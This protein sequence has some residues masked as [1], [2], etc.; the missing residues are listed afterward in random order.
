M[1]LIREW[2]AVALQADVSIVRDVV[3]LRFRA[4]MFTVTRNAVH[5]HLRGGKRQ[6]IGSDDSHVRD[7][8]EQVAVPDEQEEWENEYQKRLFAWACDEVR[9]EF[10]EHTWQAFWQTA[11]N[12]HGSSV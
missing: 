7:R 1:S 5:K 12:D 10:K 11:V 9:S 4:R 6:P 3:T 8:L 2:G